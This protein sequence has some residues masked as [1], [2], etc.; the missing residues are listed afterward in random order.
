MADAG[1]DALLGRPRPFATAP[2]FWSDQYGI[3]LQFAGSAKPEDELHV[4]HGTMEEGRFVALYGRVGRLVGVLAVKRPAQLVRYRQW[5][6]QRTSFPE[7][8]AQ[9]K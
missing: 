9:A 5:I 4:C 7:A 3:K 1:A 8:V 6:E 2:V